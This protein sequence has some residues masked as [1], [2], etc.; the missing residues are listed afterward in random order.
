MGAPFD[1]GS[2]KLTLR[3]LVPSPVI[4]PPQNVTQPSDSD[5]H[6][7]E[8]SEGEDTQKQQLLHNSGSADF[9]LPTI[10]IAPTGLL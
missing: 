8:L 2:M 6:A 7:K 4:N 9:I 10:N 1:S 5:R 3:G